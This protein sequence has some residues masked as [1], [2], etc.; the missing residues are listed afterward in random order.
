MIDTAYVYYN[1]AAIGRTLKD[2]LESGRIK[3]EDLFITSKV[4]DPSR[5]IVNYKISE[6]EFW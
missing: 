6:S 1:E 2:W 5:Y 3:R 4:S